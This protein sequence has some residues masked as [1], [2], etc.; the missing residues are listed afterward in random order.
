MP[1]N[2]MN[3]ARQKPGFILSQISP[4]WQTLGDDD[5]TVCPRSPDP[6]HIVE[7]Y[8]IRLLGH[9]VIGLFLGHKINDEKLN[10]KGG[11]G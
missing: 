8:Y 5:V 10:L 6:F 11:R 4:P 1:T 2:T 9:T 7:I 3:Y